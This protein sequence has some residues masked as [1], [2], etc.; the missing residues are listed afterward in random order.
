VIIAFS[1]KL[2]APCVCRER[3]TCHIPLRQEG[4]FT[5]YRC[6]ACG[7]VSTYEDG[8]TESKM[9]FVCDGYEEKW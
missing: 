5:V 1:N 3:P 7:H 6:S 8:N 2:A 4:K 9:R